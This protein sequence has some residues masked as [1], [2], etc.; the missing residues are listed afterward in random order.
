MLQRVGINTVA[1]ESTGVYWIPLF[2]ILEARGLE[3]FRVNARHVKNVPGRKTDL[4]DCQWLQYLHSVGLLNRS[5]RPAQHICAARSLFRHRDS[6]IEMAASHVQHLHKALD[7]M[8]LQIHHVITG[9]TGLAILD[10]ILGGRRDPTELAKLRDRWIKATPETIIKSLRGDYQ[11]EHLFT[12]KQALAAYRHD[13]Q[14]IAEC[15]REIAGYL[16]QF[17]SRCELPQPEAPVPGKRGRG[18]P[19]GSHT[20]EAALHRELHRIFGVDLVQVPG[21][22]VSTVMTL[23]TEIGP[24]LSKF[25]SSRAFASW[26]ALCPDNDK[27]GGQVVATGTRPSKSRAPGAFRMAA[28]SLHG[29]FSFLGEYY[30]RFRA[31]LGAPKAITAAAHKLARIF[32]HLV[33]TQQANDESIFAEQETIHRQRL[34]RRL[35]TQARLLGFEL[36]PVAGV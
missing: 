25:R 33:T 32:F 20:P 5:Y 35:K 9:Q 21:F 15:D 23:A 30:R 2:Q 27:T 24:D 18:R 3:V 11:P 6:L 34:Q 17:G 4:S 29:S 36:V 10:A 7:Q 13:Q 22:D 16:R 31:R 26:L 19:R 8:N 12:L 14:L 1:M 28:Y